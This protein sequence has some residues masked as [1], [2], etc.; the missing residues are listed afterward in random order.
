MEVSHLPEEYLRICED[1]GTPFFTAGEKAFY[2]S[3]NIR[4]PKRCKSCR[5]ERKQAWE[6]E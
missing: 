4:L 2:E 3:K 1:C 5:T 6:Q